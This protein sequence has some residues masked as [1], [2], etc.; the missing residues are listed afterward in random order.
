MPGN[1]PEIAL[2]EAAFACICVHPRLLRPFLAPATA[3]AQHN[4]PPAVVGVLLPPPGPYS[5][6]RPTV[7]IP[8]PAAFTQAPQRARGRRAENARPPYLDGALCF[9]AQNRHQKGSTRRKS[10]SGND[11][12][13]L[14]FPDSTSGSVH[15][16]ARKS[17]VIA[18]GHPLKLVV[19]PNVRPQFGA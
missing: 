18:L 13:F 12:F 10:L 2:L 6:V 8:L 4:H 14:F 19:R 16:F 11:E 9:C 1:P 15:D 17:D 7:A 5:L 3:K